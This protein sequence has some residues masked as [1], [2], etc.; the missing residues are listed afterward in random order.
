VTNRDIFEDLFIL[1]MANHLGSVEQDLKIIREFSHVVRSNKV[2][3]SIKLQFTDQKSGK[4]TENYGLSDGDCHVLAKAI[5]EA[6][7]IVTAKPLDLRSVDLCVDL[8]IPIFEISDAQL[9]DW[10]LLETIATTKKP[11]VLSSRSLPS[12]DIDDFVAFFARLNVPL[13]IMHCVAIEVRKD[14][15]LEINQ[16]DLLRSRYPNNTIGYSTHEYMSATSSMMI[17]YAKGARMFER[18][19]DMDS[20][21]LRGA[22]KGGQPEQIDEW[23][24]A[25]QKVKKMCGGPG[26]RPQMLQR[27]E[28]SDALLP[29][30]YAKRNLPKGHSLTTDDVYLAFPLQKGQ[31]S[32]LELTGGEILT[33]LVK[34]DQAIQI[35]SHYPE[36][37]SLRKK[38]Y[39]RKSNVN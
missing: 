30:V 15:E 27:R 23:F 21:D 37:I 11:I 1:D 34:K 17:A 38:I 12:K 31:L 5:Q 32:P 39:N 3:A 29:G 36:S 20:D 8:G 7:C 26:T 33:D 4:G 16:I 9:A 25:F 35:D 6:G 14:S 18:R 22:P 2:R 28:Y 13:A 10:S 19:I 24:K